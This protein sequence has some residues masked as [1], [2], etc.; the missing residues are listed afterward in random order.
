MV[1]CRIVIDNALLSLLQMIVLLFV[2]L[3]SVLIRFI[4]CRFHGNILATYHG[5]HAKLSV[6][7]CL[8][9]IAGHRTESITDK[10]IW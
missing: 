9:A 8:E 1:I 6:S 10:L 2:I 3:I 4:G 7:Y 5:S